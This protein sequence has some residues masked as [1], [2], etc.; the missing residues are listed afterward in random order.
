MYIINNVRD[1]VAVW[2]W[3]TSEQDIGFFLP[4]CRCICNY[5]CSRCVIYFSA[6][7]NLLNFLVVAMSNMQ[8]VVPQQIHSVNGSSETMGCTSPL[9]NSDG[10]MVCRSQNYLIDG[11]SPDIDTN[12]T[13]WASQLVAVKI[14]YNK[15]IYFPHVLLTFVFDTP[16][17]VSEI[18]MDLFLCSNLS[19]DPPYII[20]YLI[21]D[22]QYN[23]T[24]FSDLYYFVPGEALSTSISSC[25]GL[26]TYSFRADILQFSYQTFHCLMSFNTITYSTEWAYIGEVRFFNESGIPVA[27]SG[28]P[29]IIFSPNILQN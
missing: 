3:K 24:L 29:A 28:I 12:T 27:P 22:V 9:E 10:V 2:I 4:D 25:D 11:C 19:I 15:H 16:V 1:G 7:F 17:S 26:T 14:T 8:V 23:L 5:I 13:D 18:E 20:I 21:N 6:I